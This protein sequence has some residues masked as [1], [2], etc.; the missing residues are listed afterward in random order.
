MRFPRAYGFG[1]NSVDLENKPPEDYSPDLDM[2]PNLWAMDISSLEK[3]VTF[4]SDTNA[5]QVFAGLTEFFAM[6]SFSLLVFDSTVSF[7][8]CSCWRSNFSFSP[9]MLIYCIRA[10]SCN[11]ELPFIKIFLFVLH[12]P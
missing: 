7:L 5:A 12:I 6:D 2:L 9:K 3:L 1:S 8:Y 4:S 10:L 11:L